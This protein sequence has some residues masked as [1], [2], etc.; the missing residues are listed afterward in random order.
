MAGTWGAGLQ[1]EL[2]I[3]KPV[4]TKL[5]LFY[6]HFSPPTQNII[7]IRNNWGIKRAS[8]CRNDSESFFFFFFGWTRPAGLY[9]LLKPGP[10][11][12]RVFLITSYH[13]FKSFVSF[14][15]SYSMFLVAKPHWDQRGP[16]PSKLFGK[17]N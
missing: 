13:E 6:S 14:S 7:Y 16:W 8:T 4:L 3:S 9:P 11:N 2:P 17:K 10:F 12:K 15:L 5:S 1:L